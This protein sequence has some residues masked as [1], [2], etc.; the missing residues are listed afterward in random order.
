[1]HRWAIVQ[2]KMSRSTSACPTPWQVVNAR[3]EPQGQIT[4]DSTGTRE[5]YEGGRASNSVVVPEI[6]TVPLSRTLDAG[7]FL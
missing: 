1:M 7:K 2:L 3:P 4:S 6:V 5:G